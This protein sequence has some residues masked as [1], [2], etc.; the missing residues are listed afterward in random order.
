M[1]HDK[2]KTL[3]RAK[4]RRNVL[5]VCV[6]ASISLLLVVGL[7]LIKNAP[8]KIEELTEQ[9]DM[10]YAEV[11]KKTQDSVES[12]FPD[13]TLKSDD[14]EKLRKDETVYVI[15]DADG[16]ET[17]RVVS[18]WLKNPEKLDTIKDK[19]K[20]KDI[21]N[22]N[23][24]EKFEQDGKKV[25]WAAG[26][27]D[28]KYTGES[29]ADLPVSVEV[30]Y[31]LD[32]EQ[33]SADEIAGQSGDVEIHFDY[34]VNAR[35]RVTSDGSGYD[36][37]HPYIMASGVVLDN[38]K[39]SDVEVSTG[40][41]LNESGS[42]V[43]LGIAL[44]GMQDNLALDKDMIDIPESVV[45]KANTTDFK[46]DGTYTVALTGLFENIDADTDDITDKLDELESGLG[47]LSDASTK[48][49]K[50]SKQLS[51]GADKL[52]DGTSS[53]ASGTSKLN[54]SSKKLADGV[55]KLKNGSKKLASGTSAIKEGTEAAEKGANQISAGLDQLSGNSEALNQGTQQIE[56]SVFASATTQLQA[57]LVAGG[58]PEEQ[59]EKYVLTPSSYADVL[60]K[61]SE[62][63]PDYKEAF[64]QVK[65]SL[66][67]VEKYVGSVK[68][69]TDG[70]DQIAAGADQ[71]SSSMGKLTEGAKAVDE[72]AGQVYGGLKSLSGKMPELKK[73]ISQLNSGAQQIDS[74]AGQLAAGSDKLSSGIAKFDKDGIK[75]LTGEL[76][77]DEI[78]DT[79]GRL[80]A[81]SKAS[82]K[83]HFMGGSPKNIQGESR[84][85]FKTGAV[86]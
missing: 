74:G 32:G 65:G 31:Y 37:T 11:A 43:C 38:D 51:K 9:S 46:I 56:S 64:G 84:I 57:M 78:T 42:S 44:P 86:E 13:I 59:A 68:T 67:S 28:I 41:V 8:A 4:A 75:K 79:L 26:G 80:E 40:R 12:S 34:G 77:T 45:I 69:Y 66:D 22:T 10:S 6:I 39:F 48:L 71:L 20:L 70:V 53:L 23:G 54:K 29:D 60:A 3:R 55:K 76:D 21:R 18:E 81:I 30:T 33:V 35:D 2:A 82:G 73:G 50:G 19:T 14:A 72:G 85:I 52:S 1:K 62:A 5:K 63:L 83:K 61:L 47:K 58:M 27:N 16:N 15:M 49:V 17:E 36:L 7:V 25:V 24:D